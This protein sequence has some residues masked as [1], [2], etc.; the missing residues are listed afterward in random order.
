MASDEIRDL[1]GNIEQQRPP[2]TTDEGWRSLESE[3]I[4]MFTPNAPINEGTLFAGRIDQLRRM[5]DT[6]YQ[7]GQHAI[8]YG[9]RGVGKTSLAN[10]IHS[11]IFVRTS[12]VRAL[13]V[14]STEN[15]DFATIWK[16]IFDDF[17]AGDLTA[18]E[19]IDIDPSPFRVFKII[20]GFSL[21]EIPILIIDEFDRVKDVQTQNQIADLIKY[22]SDYSANATVIIVGVAEDVS[23]LFKEHPS[24]PRSMQQILMPR[25]SADELSTIITDRLPQLGM[26]IERNIK[27]KIVR[28]SQGLPSYTHLLG[29]L[30]AINAALRHSVLIEQTDFDAAIAASLE[31]SQA[32]LR[33]I[34]YRAIDSSKPNAQFRQ[35]LLACALSKTDEMGRFPTIALREPFSLIMGR[36]M[37]ISNYSQHLAAFCSDDRGPVLEKTG[38][39]KTYK[40][41]FCEPMLQPLVVMNGLREDLITEEQVS[42]LID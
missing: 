2:P 22:L 15:D 18:T 1:F 5:V 34:Y 16:K 41:R 28:F 26:S 14:N 30:G 35:A 36:P 13:K 23:A 8:L 25:M 6:V 21:N 3:I 10:I 11:K 4:Q 42:A 12:S 7:R 24:L 33:A 20:E 40:F 39:P 19:I 38:R 17:Q 9:Q 32:H 27:Q 31:E 29:K 37:D